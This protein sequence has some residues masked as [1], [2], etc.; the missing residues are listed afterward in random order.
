MFLYN[1]PNVYTVFDFLDT[2]IQNPTKIFKNY[3]YIINPDKIGEVSIK[4][5]SHQDSYT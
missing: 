3:L 5:L 4:N 1:H 2:K